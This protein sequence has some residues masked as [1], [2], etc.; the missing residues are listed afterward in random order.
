MFTWI[1][2]L[3]TKPTPGNTK[4]RERLTTVDLLVKGIKFCKKVNNI[5]Y[6][7]ISALNYLVHGGQL[8]WV[9]PS[10][11]D[12]LLAPTLCKQLNEVYRKGP[13]KKQ[14]WCM[15]KIFIQHASLPSFVPCVSCT[16]VVNNYESFLKL[17]KQFYFLK[18]KI[19]SYL[20]KTFF[21]RRNRKLDLVIKRFFFVN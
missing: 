18:T 11:K 21:W 3:A 5:F 19:N 2:A 8:Y 15:F 7:K 4:W 14:M 20:L 1:F 9:F 13:I 17:S 12:S 10:S 6:I 16:V